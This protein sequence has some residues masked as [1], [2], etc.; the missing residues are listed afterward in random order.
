MFYVLCALFVLLV[1]WPIARGF[2]IDMLRLIRYIGTELMIVVGTSSSESVFPRLHA[3]L[4]QLGVDPPI[5]SLVLP[6]G[7]A[8]NHDG[9]CLYFSSVAVFLAQAVGIQLSIGQQVG[10]LA[11]LLATSKGGA[12]V[13]GSAIVVLA[14]TLSATGTIPVAS[15]GLILG[16][17]RLRSSAFVPVNVLGNAIATLAIARMEGAIDMPTFGSEL[18]RRAGSDVAGNVVA[19][20][21]TSGGKAW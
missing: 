16:V 8:F 13:A 6:T 20:A 2:R 12:G 14:S 1:L 19:A 10:L 5:V 7:Y 11:I 17:H 18:H 9:T 21:T 3:K 15:V 4:R